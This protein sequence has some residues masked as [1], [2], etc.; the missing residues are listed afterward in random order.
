M[1]FLSTMNWN[2]AFAWHET[3]SLRY[4]VLDV[5]KHRSPS[6]GPRGYRY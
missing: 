4:S 2:N 3:Y 5:G 6:T 1:K